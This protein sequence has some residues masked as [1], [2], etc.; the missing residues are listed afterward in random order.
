MENKLRRIGDKINVSNEDENLDIN[1]AGCRAYL[2]GENGPAAHTCNLG[3][4]NKEEIKTTSQPARA[5]E[6]RLQW[7]WNG[8]ERTVFL[9][10]DGRDGI[11]LDADSASY[12]RSL[13][14]LAQQS[15]AKDA[16]IERLTRD[17]EERSHGYSIRAKFLSE[18][19]Q[20]AERERDSLR[21]ALTTIRDRSGCTCD[22]LDDNCCAKVGV[23]CDGCFA[24][25]AL[26]ALKT[27]KK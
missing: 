24:A 2:G 20:V 9:T 22:H 8:A 7:G 5:R 23:E 12:I 10:H 17:L 3:K 26:A 1:C 4:Q 18:Q 25:S 15:A 11:R 6:W 21:E 14:E 13:M 27:S 16:E 19:F